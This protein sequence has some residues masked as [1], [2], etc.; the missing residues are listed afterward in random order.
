MLQWIKTHKYSLAGLYLFV[1]LAGFF[2]MERLVPVP[3]YIIHCRLDD[4]IPFNEWFVLPYFL[5][6]LWVP[7][8]MV[9]FMLRDKRAYLELCFIMF[10][11]AT[12]CLIIYAVWPNGLNL[13]QEITAD[14]FCADIMRFLRSVDTSTNV[15]PSIHVSSTVAVH[16]VICRSESFRESRRMKGISLLATVAICAAT[17]CIKQHSVIDVFWGWALSQALALVTWKAELYWM[18]KREKDRRAKRPQREAA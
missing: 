3:K 5:W 6:S 16:L 11:G 13:R 14:N 12:L 7:V 18:E 15:C 10:A 8:F 2:L 4:L 1:F 9:Y 17:V